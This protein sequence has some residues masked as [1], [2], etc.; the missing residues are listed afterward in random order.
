[1]EQV[2]IA[3]PPAGEYIVTVDY[4]GSLTGEMQPY[5]LLISGTDVDS[6]ADGMSDYWES[7]Y[8]FSTTGAVATADSDGD[9]AD[10]LTEFISGHNPKDAASV[11]KVVAFYGTSS[12]NNHYALIWN[13]VAGRVCNVSWVDDLADSAFT[14]ISGD[15]YYPVNSFTD[16]V[17]RAGD[18]QFY[19]IEIR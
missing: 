13:P 16:T 12:A 11:F 10:N 2:Y 4:D 17:E 7:T 18:E 6:D 19:R 3:T 5:S 8:F 9:G 15:L 14:N 1:V